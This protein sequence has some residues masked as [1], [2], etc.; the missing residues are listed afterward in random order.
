MELLAEAV[1]DPSGTTSRVLYEA[2]IPIALAMKQ[3]EAKSM[4]VSLDAQ[5][6]AKPMEDPDGFASIAQVKQLEKQLDGAGQSGADKRGR[7]DDGDGFRTR[8]SC[9]CGRPGH[10]ARDCRNKS[11]GGGGGGGAAGGN[12]GQTAAAAAE[13]S[14][15]IIVVART[16]TALPL[17]WDS[18]SNLV[19]ALAVCQMELQT[20]KFALARL[21][22]F[23]VHHC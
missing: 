21:A 20:S 17:Y 4:G 19:A 10:I 13:S 2:L 14:S 9:C 1:Q 12:K 3:A 11:S 15:I 7:L 22:H 6:F 5:A 16:F 23:K 18:W 8:P